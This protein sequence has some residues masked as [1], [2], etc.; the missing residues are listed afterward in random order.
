MPRYKFIKFFEELSIKDVPR[1]GGKNASLGEMYSALSKKGLRVPN[2]F[3]TTADAYRYFLDSAGL[4][5]Q[6]RKILK[7]L[8]THNVKDLMKRGEAIRYLFL[9]PLFQKI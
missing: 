8:D 4:K 7:G 6:I 2:G 5:P 9:T 1:V 3:A